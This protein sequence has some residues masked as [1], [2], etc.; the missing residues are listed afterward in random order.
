MHSGSGGAQSTPRRPPAD[1]QG[2]A[3]KGKEWQGGEDPPAPLTLLHPVSRSPAFGVQGVVGK[4]ST[5]INTLTGE[6]SLFYPSK[7]SHH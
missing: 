3:G 7:Y 4:W 1:P 6:K 5:F 2:L